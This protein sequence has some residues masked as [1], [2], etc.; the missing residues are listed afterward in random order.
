MNKTHLKK[1]IRISTDNF[2]I[3]DGILYEA[4]NLTKYI[5]NIFLKITDGQQIY[6]IAFLI[7]QEK[8][9]VFTY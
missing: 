8:M 2:I 9:T 4:K 1:E 6:R 3:T 7:I 5:K